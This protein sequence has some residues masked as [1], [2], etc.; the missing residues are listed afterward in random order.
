MTARILPRGEWERLK[1]TYAEA[2][3]PLLFE[4]AKVVVVEDDHGQIVG[5]HLLQPVLHAECLWVHPDHRKRAAVPRRL[6]MKVQQVARECFGA[7]A[8]C[9]AAVDDDVERLLAKVGATPVDARFFMV[10]L[11]GR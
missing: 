2:A 1:G 4:N 8:L 11:G 10:P 9:T 7:Q 5:C 6:W 3:L